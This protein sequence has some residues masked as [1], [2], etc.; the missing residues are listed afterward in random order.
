MQELRTAQLR[1]GV[2]LVAGIAALTAVAATSQAAEPDAECEG[3]RFTA[4]GENAL[5]TCASPQ[6]A[7]ITNMLVSGPGV[8]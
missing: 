6:F 7:G 4:Q 2:G 3:M 8:R 5:P 1:W